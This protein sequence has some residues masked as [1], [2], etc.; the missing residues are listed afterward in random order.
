MENKQTRGELQNPSE[1][2][3]P[4]R[5]RQGIDK[6]PGEETPEGPIENV[7]AD[8]QKGKQQVDADLDEETDRAVDQQ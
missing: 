2:A 3:G 8:T 5:D 1:M 7:V 4:H 6:A